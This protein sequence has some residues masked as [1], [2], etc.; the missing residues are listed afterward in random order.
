MVMTHIANKVFSP[1]SL[2]HNFAPNL[3]PFLLPAGFSKSLTIHFIYRNPLGLSISK[4]D[5]LFEKCAMFREAGGTQCGQQSQD[6][7]LDGPFSS[8]GSKLEQVPT[9]FQLLHP[10]KQLDNKNTGKPKH[11][12]WLYK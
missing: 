12:G 11:P 3:L 9:S 6:N 5:S 8:G 2:I 4:R 7:C 10:N 1:F